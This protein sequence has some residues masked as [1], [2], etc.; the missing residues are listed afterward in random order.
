MVAWCWYRPNL[1]QAYETRSDTYL[2]PAMVALSGAAPESNDYKSFA[3]L[4]CYSAVAGSE[5][6]A[7]SFYHPE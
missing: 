4:L 5:G 7:P 6:T 1:S 3:L 2:P